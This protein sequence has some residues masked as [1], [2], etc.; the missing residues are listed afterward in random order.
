[1]RIAFKEWAIVV[2]SLGTGRQIVILRKGGIS[3]GRRGFQV[4]HAEF[5]LYPTRVH[6]DRESV[7]P[8]SQD[9]FDQAVAAAG[10]EDPTQVRFEYFAHVI[11]WR[12]LET[13]EQVERLRG[14]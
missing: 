1:M 2:D 13:L 3:E 8:S 6:Q 4:E 14:Q 7:V 10:T 5:L 11:S 12:K 9:R